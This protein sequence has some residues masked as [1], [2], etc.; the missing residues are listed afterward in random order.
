METKPSEQDGKFALLIRLPAGAPDEKLEVLSS[1]K[2]IRVEVVMSQLRAFLRNMEFDYF[3]EFRRDT[4][5]P[6]QGGEP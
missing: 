5:E 3:T 4:S 2:G 1:R 6:T